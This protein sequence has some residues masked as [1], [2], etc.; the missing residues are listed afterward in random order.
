MTLDDIRR[1]PHYPFADFQGNDLSFLML[2]LYWV[3]LF[4]HALAQAGGDAG[5][6]Q[7]QAPADRED[8]NPILQLINRQL[9]PPRVLRVV[10]RFNTEHLPALDLQTLAPV[11]TTGDV[12]VA[13]VPGL[14]TGAVDDDGS[15]PIDE[16]VISSDLSPAC[17]KL[18]AHF[19]ARWCAQPVSEA[20]MRQAEQAYWARVNAALPAA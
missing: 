2:E 12:Y 13:F 9:Q 11:A 19:A 5:H 8:G 1:H 17:E 16:L 10:Q 4:A 15:S 3:E 7:P 18:F 6:W 14:T 20:Q